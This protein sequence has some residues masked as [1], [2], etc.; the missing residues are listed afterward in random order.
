MN[1]WLE[2]ASLTTRSC[3]QGEGR[4]VELVPMKDLFLQPDLVCFQGEGR[5]VELVPM[6][7]LFLQPTYQPKFNF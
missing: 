5:L 6:K 2:D 1:K 4:L 3:F 7:D